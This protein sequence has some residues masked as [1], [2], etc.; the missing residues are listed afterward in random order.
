MPYNSNLAYDMD[1]EAT[2]ARIDKKVKE[3]KKQNKEK[4]R[5]EKRRLHRAIVLC[6]SMF[7][8]CAAFMISR[9][10]TAYESR[11]NVEKLQKELNSLKEYSSQ[12]AF[13]LDSSFNREEIE[14]EAKTR[15]NMVRPEKYQKVYVN[16]KQD[17]VTEI[18][19][20]DAAGIGN[21]FGIFAKKGQ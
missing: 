10:V 4:A 17:D 12:K 20:K 7:A 6:I 9:N 13:E 3:Q 2:A 19:A 11:R 1:F 8:V 15:L 5:A 16:I 21:A 18:T 14:R